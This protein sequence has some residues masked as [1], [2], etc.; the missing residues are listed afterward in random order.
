MSLAALLYKGAIAL[1]IAG[2]LYATYRYTAKQGRR[3]DS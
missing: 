2:V 3:S 1:I